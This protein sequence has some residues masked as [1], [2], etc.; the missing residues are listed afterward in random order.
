MFYLDFWMIYDIF[1][2]C[3]CIYNV[4]LDKADAGGNCDDES[5]CDLNCNHS[6]C[7]IYEVA[8]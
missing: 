2:G 5:V 8:K 1:P 4:Y 7:F 6:V 3:P